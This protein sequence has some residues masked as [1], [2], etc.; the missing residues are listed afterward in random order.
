MS[1]RLILASASPRRLELLA[2]VGVRPHAVVPADVD[3][4][5]ALRELPRVLAERL[6]KAKAEAVAAL[7]PEDFILA[8]DT[9]VAMGL[10][11]LGKPADADEAARFLSA[12]SGRRHRVIG[13]LCAIAPDGRCSLRSVVTHVRFK[14]L[15]KV[16]IAAYVESGEWQGK[17]GGYAIQGLAAAFVPSINGS[18][19][20]VVG[21]SLT[22]ALAQLRGLGFTGA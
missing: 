13:G 14:R 12:L 6:A 21:L 4:T 17:A 5:P 18:Y 9:V 19:A 8:A 16:E 2:Q 11:T 22:D 15:T 3:E 7:Y 10:R 20:N 1:G